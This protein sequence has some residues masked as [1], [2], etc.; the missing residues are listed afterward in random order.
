M[1]SLF[2]IQNE[3]N[4]VL[5]ETILLVAGIGVFAWFIQ[6]DNYLIA[7]AFG[8]LL[9][10]SLV[11]SAIIVKSESPAEIFGIDRFNKRILLY[12]LAGV[13]IGVLPAFYGRYYYD[14]PDFPG[15][16]TIIALVSP[17]IGITE[18][19]VFRGFVQGRLR[20]LGVFGSVSIAAAAHTIYKFFILWSVNELVEVNFLALTGLTFFF[21]IIYGLLRAGSRSVLPAL[22]AHAFF[23][24]LMY[25]DFTSMPVWVWG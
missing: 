5:L 14:L 4:S 25:G 11:I 16:L 19:L 8:G 7:V 20:I 13:I 24:L 9:L 18:E 10:A 3:K 2:K 15:S 1:T 12:C 21:G 6:E 17:L 22:V 23:D